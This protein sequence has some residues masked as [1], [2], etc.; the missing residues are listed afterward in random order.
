M[1]D[2][3][4]NNNSLTMLVHGSLSEIPQVTSSL[5]QNTKQTDQVKYQVKEPL[6]ND[7]T[8]QQLRVTETQL[9]RTGNKG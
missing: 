9:I 1:N 6:R 3:I 8:D 4:H 7:L 2:V 5:V